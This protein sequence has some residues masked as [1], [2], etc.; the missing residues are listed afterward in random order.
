ML[1]SKDAL[2]VYALIWI[3]FMNTNKMDQS[4]AY[5][6]ISVRP[7]RDIHFVRIVPSLLLFQ[8]NFYMLCTSL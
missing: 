2:Y 8:S 5:L 4:L 3:I 7:G 1:I 6:P